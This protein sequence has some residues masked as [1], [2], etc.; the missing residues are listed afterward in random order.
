M[1]KYFKIIILTAIIVFLFGSCNSININ[2]D[3]IEEMI[4]LENKIDGTG[5]FISLPENYYVTKNMGPDFDVYYI[6]SNGINSEKITNGGIYFGNHP[7]LFGN[8]EETDLQFIEYSI[9]KIFNKN[10]KWKI[11][12]SEHNYFAEIITRNNSGEEWNRYIHIWA[13]GKT[14]KDLYKI[15]YLYSTLRK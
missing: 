13:N 2:K 5:Y 10:R 9:C 12:N 1:Y 15:I 14:K 11:Y 8:D 7:S 4:L 6:N 3:N